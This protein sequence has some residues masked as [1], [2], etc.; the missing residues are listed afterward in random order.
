VPFYIGVG[1][2]LHD[3]D[4]GRYAYKRAYE[5][6]QRNRVWQRTA[7]AGYDIEIM[8]ESESKEFICQKEIEFISLYGRL[9]DQTGTLAN[10]NRGG[11]LQEGHRCKTGKPTFVYKESGEFV[12][13]F[14][15]KKDA[16]ISLGFSKK[17]TSMVSHAE[18]YGCIRKGYLFFKE[19]LGDKIDKY[20]KPKGYKKRVFVRSVKGEFLCRYD[21][22]IDCAV[23]ENLSDYKIR[24]AIDKGT[25]IAGRKYSFKGEDMA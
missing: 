5:K 4:H 18:N 19:F 14:K 24:L 22:I 3:D 17:S 7:S 13:E 8:L 21:S 12:G 16:A 9:D 11:A 1:K 10:R 2:K 23:G 20:D 25:S 15:T 6:F